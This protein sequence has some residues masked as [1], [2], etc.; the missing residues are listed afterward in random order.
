MPLERA[1]PPYLA[2]TRTNDLCVPSTQARNLFTFHSLVVLQGYGRFIASIFTGSTKCKNFTASKRI[3]TPGNPTSVRM[4]HAH[5]ET[6]R[7]FIHYIYTGKI[8]LQDNDIFEMLGLA[9]E[10]GVEELWTSCEE[11]VSATLSP[12]NA[13]A[14]LTAALDAQE[15]VSVLDD[16]EEY[17]MKTKNRKPLGRIM[18]KG[19][20]ITLIQNTNPGA[21]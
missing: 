3:G 11:H 18:L 19:D 14:L 17:H 7:Q 15:R 5:P 2:E 4:P 16:A 21:N 6:F 13:C 20:N 9:Q 12:G 10:L 8:M 1:L